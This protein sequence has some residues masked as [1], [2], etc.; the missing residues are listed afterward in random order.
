MPIDTTLVINFDKE[1]AYIYL[2]VRA[3]LQN[4]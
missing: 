4:E 2:C 1:L 3:M